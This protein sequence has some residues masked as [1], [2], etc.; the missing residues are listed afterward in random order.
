MP[1]PS[2][3]PDWLR[4]VGIGCGALLLV[5]S[6]VGLVVFTVVKKATAGPEKTV[7]AF[8]TAA[9]NGDFAAAHAYFAE[10][11]KQVQPLEQFREVAKA[12]QH[13]FQVQDTTFNNRSVDLQ[14]A[15]LSGTVTLTGG[16]QMPCEFKLVREGNAWKLISYHIGSGSN[17]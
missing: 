7:E 5:S 1:P 6:V 11:L 16:T 3:L 10:P 15:E 12:N 4:W 14:G 8:L 13:L 2:S 9:G 17:G